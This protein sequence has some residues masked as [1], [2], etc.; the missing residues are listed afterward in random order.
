MTAATGDGVA[1]DSNGDGDGDEEDSGNADA[2][3][4]TC[5]QR[6]HTQIHPTPPHPHTH[7]FHVQTAGTA[8]GLQASP[9]L[10]YKQVC[11]WTASKSAP[12]LQVRPWTA[13]PTQTAWTMFNAVAMMLPTTGKHI[14]FPTKMST[15][16][17]MV[18]ICWM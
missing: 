5:M 18:T 1:G 9:P 11:P 7:R 10:D 17:P 16:E 6:A 8:L 3:R 12:G 4:R 13:Q 2:C 15:S 14:A